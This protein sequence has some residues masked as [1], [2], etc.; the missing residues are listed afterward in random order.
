MMGKLL[1]L[2]DMDGTLIT[3][4]DG[5]KYR[6]VSTGYTTYVSLRQM[7]MD[8]AISCGVPAEEYSGLNRM[9]LIWN[10][11]RAYAEEQGYDRAEVETLMRAIN[12]P[13]T[14]EESVEHA[15]SFLLPG[16]IE[17]LEALMQ[18]GHP[19]GIVTT[20]SRGAYEAVS[21]SPEFGRFGRFFRHSITRDDCDYIKPHREPM[22]RAMQLFGRIDYAYIGDS[23]HDAQAAM[24][25]GGTF[26][27]INT[28]GYDEE[29]V[30][31]LSPHA[32]I[33]RLTELPSLLKEL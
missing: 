20:A 19:M 3:I 12:G 26:I 14:K 2:F 17:V 8:V 23:D 1:L 28:R 21:R 9:A 5:P 4:R 16:T 33:Q 31:T 7:M 11:T 10:R 25:A 27:L 13:F 29:T 24:A 15:R 32:V 6:G 22:E 30:E 18:E